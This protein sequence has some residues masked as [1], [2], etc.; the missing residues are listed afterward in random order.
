MFERWSYL[1]YTLI[2]CLPPLVT[3]WMRQEFARRLAKDL[4]R[5]LAATAILTL[6]GSIM[7]PMALRAGAWAYADNRILNIKLLGYVHFED[8]LWWLLVSFLMA[9]FVSLSIRYE[10]EGVDIFAREIQGLLRSFACALRGF[11]MLRL[12]RNL[13]IHTAA[14]TFVILE[15]AFLKVSALE[16]SVLLLAVGAVVGLELLNSAIERVGSRLIPGQSEEIRLIKDAAAAAVLWASM[17]AAVVGSTIFL[18]RIV[19]RI[20]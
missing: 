2:F 11:H 15:A 12:E 9:S 20:L 19:P 6:Y 18:P 13:T 5:I 7:W 1:G 4:Y 10:D 3:L 16:W 8:T 17:I 14:A